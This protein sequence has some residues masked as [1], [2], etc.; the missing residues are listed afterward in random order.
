VNN[1]LLKLKGNPYINKS[2]FHH[3]LYL[4][5]DILLYRKRKFFKVKE[6]TIA[7]SHIVQ[8]DIISGIIFSSISILNPAT[9]TIEIKG[10][11]KHIAKKAK[12]IIDQKIHMAHAKHSPAKMDISNDMV[13][14][15]KSLNRLDELLQRGL[16]TDKEY[17]ERRNDLMDQV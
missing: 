6:V 15:E 3:R 4:Y 14:Y 7:Y 17:D 12:K 8:V 5:D 13:K 1:L 16:I 2:I 10:V 9:D 11:P